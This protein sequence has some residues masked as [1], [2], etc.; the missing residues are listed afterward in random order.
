MRRYAIKR[1]LVAVP[2]VLGAT[3][4]VFSILVL[5]P[6]DPASLMLGHRATP[7]RVAELRHQL[8]LDQPVYVQYVR[9]LSGAVRGDLGISV[10]AKRSAT[11]LILE[12]LPFTLQLTGAALIISVVVGIP[13][14]V[15]SAVKQYTIVDYLGMSAALFGL[16]MPEFWLGLMLMLL[17]GLTLGVLP[18]SGYSGPKSLIL[19]AVTLSLREL[20]TLARLMRSEMLEVIREDYVTTARAKGLR[21]TLVMYKH[22]LRNAVIPVVVYLFLGIPWLISGAVVIES[23]FAWPGMGQL[24]YKS[25]LAKDF[26]IV[27][28]IVLLIALLTVACNLLGDIVTAILDPRIRLG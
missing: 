16:S 20:G 27:Q 7:E 10:V 11:A 18:I 19:P 3:I 25:I 12:R 8:G 28:G 23:V 1:L 21:E 26:P 15:I 4:V 5:T 22:A 24:L 2:V 17:F 6:G 9:W 14:G 13:V